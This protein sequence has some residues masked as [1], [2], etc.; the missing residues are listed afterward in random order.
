MRSFRP[1]PH[2]SLPLRF[3]M[4]VCLLCVSLLPSMAGGEVITLKNGYQLT[5]KVGRLASIAQ[6]PLKPQDPDAAEL[7]V[8]VDD[9]LRRIFVPYRNVQAIAPVD[10]IRQERIVVE[11]RKAIGGARIS[12]VG[13]PLKIEPFDEWGRR[14]FTMSTA[15]GPIHVIQGITLV[16]PVYTQL[17]ALI[18]EKQYQWTTRIATSSVPRDVLSRVLRRAAGDDP[19]QRMRIVRLYIQ[20]ERYN[21]ARA[22]VEECIK[23]FPE[24]TS[25]KQQ[26]QA[27]Q[28]ASAMRLVKEIELRRDS[29]QHQLVAAMCSS[30]PSDGV[31]GETLIRVGEI[32]NEY[33]KLQADGKHVLALMDQFLAELTDDKQRE[34]IAPI[35]EEIGTNLN[36][37][38]LV[39]MADFLRLADAGDLTPDRKLSLAISGWY[40]GNGE[41]TENLSVAVSLY[42]V[43]NLVRAYL[44]STHEGERAEILT[45]LE[46]L[47]G[48][49]PTYLAKILRHMRPAVDTPPSETLPPG[50]QLISVPGLSG[51]PDIEYYV[52]LPPEYDPYRRYPAVVTLNSAISTPETQINWWAG[53]YDEKRKM[54]LGQASRQGYVVIAPKWS[55]VHQREYEFTAHEHAAV[56]FSVRDA[57]T[58]FSI[59]S[60]RIYLSGHSMGG[61]AAW[62][63]A[64][65]HPDLWAGVIP[66]GAS[67]EKYMLRYYPNGKHVPLYYIAGELDGN[68]FANCANVLDKYL[69]HS[70]Y[71]AVIVQYQGRGHEHFYDDIQNIF[72]WMKYHVRDPLPKEFECVSMRPWDNFFWWVEVDHYPANT[73]VLPAMWPPKR[74]FGTAST[75]GRI[76]SPTSLFVRSSADAAT[77]WLTPEMVNFEGRFTIKFNGRDYSQS[78]QPSSAVML[79]DARTRGDRQH[80][81]WQKVELGRK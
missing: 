7:I 75:E 11:Q 60:D 20:A 59:D 48:S 29:G 5:G 19:D 17:D 67:A 47:E 3:A 49:S 21:D 41:A 15:D 36:Y 64:V 81:F 68:R 70:N 9:D 37:H 16:T 18:A 4:F 34:K 24:V 26:V 58:R 77:V 78:I 12:S 56:L 79:E 50:M 65:A 39:R 6:D 33:E 46:R 2:G 76:N 23:E 22:E 38:N 28:Q 32:L 35:R 31:A 63:I 62:D 57:L 13:T 40:L 44:A 25:F 80:P 43:R 30:F 72:D 55:R 14:T 1:P 45:K 52:Q 42:E 74:N 61:D 54:R 53:D 71:D 73:M 8:L 27:L 69:T 10:P 51:E 66:I